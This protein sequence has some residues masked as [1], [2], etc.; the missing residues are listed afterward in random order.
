VRRTSFAV[1]VAALFEAG[2]PRAGARRLRNSA[3]SGS[4]PMLASRYRRWRA[5]ALAETA[6]RTPSQYAQQSQNHPPG[7]RVSADSE[8]DMALDTAALGHQRTGYVAIQKALKARRGARVNQHRRRSGKKKAEGRSRLWRSW[9]APTF[10]KS[11]G[12]F[13]MQTKTTSRF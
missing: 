6:L 10:P 12:D 2:P 8:S 9:R 5:H 13:L 11:A 7:G 1:P 4:S 3:I